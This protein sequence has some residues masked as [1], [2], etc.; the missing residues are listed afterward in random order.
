MIPYFAKTL[1]GLP[2]ENSLTIINFVMS[3]NT[4]INPSTNYRTTI[5]DVLCKLSKF[6]AYANERNLKNFNRQDVINFLDNYRKPEA[7]DPFHKWIGTYNL[8]RILIVKF[9]KWLY[10]PDIEP[11]KRPKPA[12]VDNIPQ[13]KRKEKSSYKPSDMWTGEDDLL[14]IKYC[15]SKRMKCAMQ[16]QG[17]CLQDPPKYWL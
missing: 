8:Y 2:Y 5:I 9:F 7:S 6:H 1:K 4:E 3:L 17:I 11:K 14:F 16:Y 10:Y 12:V 15:P 13:L